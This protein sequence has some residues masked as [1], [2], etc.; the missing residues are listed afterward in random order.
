M[1]IET[2]NMENTMNS[3]V[4]EQPTLKKYGTMKEFTLDTGGSGGDNMGTG[5]TNQ[6]ST[7]DASFNEVGDLLNSVNSDLI[8]N[9]FQTM[10]TNQD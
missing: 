10:D 5:I 4:Y 3:L 9:D 6:D 8:N 1:S 7:P 2:E